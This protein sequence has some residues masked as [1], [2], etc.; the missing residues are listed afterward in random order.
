VVK[1]PSVK[2]P[3]YHNVDIVLP[4][5][6]LLK[7]LKNFKPDVIHYHDPFLAGTIALLMGKLLKVPTV[8]TVHIHPKQLSYHGLKIDNGVIAKK[9][10]SF[11]GSFTDCTIFVSKYQMSLYEYMQNTCKRVIYNGIPDYFFVAQKRKFR[12]YRNKILTVS[13]LDKDKNLEFALKCVSEISKV[14]PVEYTIVGDGK[15]RAKLEKLTFELG[16]K[17]H[18]LGFVP[19]EG[20]PEIYLS[21]DVLLNTSKTE[22]FGL[23]FAEAMATGMPVI[24]SKE[25]SAPEIVYNGGVLCEEDTQCVKEAFLNLFGNDEFY[26]PLSKR[27]SE[28]A[29]SF[30]CER[31][32]KDYEKLY[33][34]VSR[35]LNLR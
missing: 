11:F 19:R 16:L 12:K 29:K 17:V 8:G 24:A 4:N 25:G 27:A 7:E 20:L 34:E 1:L 13:R 5:V 3:F 21:H 28:R 33:K 10:V 30:R 18:F 26:L 6:E 14:I 35:T 22:T 15:E 23:S 31:F 2:Y 9:L 32:L